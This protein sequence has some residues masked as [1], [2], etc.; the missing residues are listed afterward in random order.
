MVKLKALWETLVDQKKIGD[1]HKKMLVFFDSPFPH[2]S[3]LHLSVGKFQEVFDS[4]DSN[5]IY[6]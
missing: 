5:A 4:S 2:A 3:I 6:G 1:I